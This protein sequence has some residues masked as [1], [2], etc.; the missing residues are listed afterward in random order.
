MAQQAAYLYW[1]F[2]L[3]NPESNDVPE[4]KAEQYISWQREE[5]EAGTE[6]LQG[7]VEFTCRQRLSALKKWLPTAHFESRKGSADQARDYTRKE[8]SRKEGPWERGTFTP[9]TQGQRTD[10][11]DCAALCATGVSE[12]EVIAQ[13]PSIFA[14]HQHFIRYHVKKAREEGVPKQ[15]IDNPHEWQTRV[16]E[17]VS[18]P[19]HPRQILW[20]YDL[21]GGTGKTMLAKYLTDHFGAFYSNG[22]KHTDIIHA[23]QGQAIA[24][25]DYV[26]E[27]QN[28]VNYGV[29]EQLKNG[30]CFS[31]KYDSGM[32]R[33]PSPHVVVF[34][35]FYP[36]SE[37]L[38]VD[39]LV[40]IEPLKCGD[41][42]VL[43]PRV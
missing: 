10:L 30:I 26:R 13:F 33:F 7:Y 40:V 14:R 4:H 2:T 36:A 24:I 20:I 35:N 43:C 22:G 8:E 21:V 25:F 12:A 1:C 28:Y 16:L 17:M 19:A 5:G 32:K 29:L 38:S 27:S 3:N 37:K 23:Y 11:D 6:H 34:A 15:Q 41:F 42:S 31:P 9:T 18:E 39:R